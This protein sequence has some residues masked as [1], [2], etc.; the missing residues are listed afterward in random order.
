VPIHNRALLV[1]GEILRARYQGREVMAEVVAEGL[2]RV[3][4]GETHTSV[5]AAAKAITGRSTNGWK[6]WSLVNVP[7]VPPEQAPLLEPPTP[8]VK[9]D[10]DVKKAT[11]ER[12]FIPSGSCDSPFHGKGKSCPDSIAVV[13]RVKGADERMGEVHERCYDHVVNILI[14][15]DGFWTTEPLDEEELARAERKV[16][17]RRRGGRKAE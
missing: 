15:W 11:P 1:P 9:V 8:D 4:G 12:P 2:I 5:S 17:L 16:D 6:F 13:T 7:D 14:Y 3:D 10:S